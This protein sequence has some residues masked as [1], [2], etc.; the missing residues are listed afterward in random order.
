VQT[1]EHKRRIIIETIE[2]PKP[3]VT[4]MKRRNILRIKFRFLPFSEKRYPIPNMKT[5]RPT[6][7]I[8]GEKSIRQV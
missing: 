8:K 3:I 4:P 7:S 5:N 1:S 2:I 6:A